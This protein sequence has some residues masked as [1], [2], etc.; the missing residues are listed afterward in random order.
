MYLTKKTSIKYISQLLTN[1]EPVDGYEEEFRIMESLHDLRCVEVQD[2]SEFTETDF[3]ELLKQLSKKNKAKY[4]F[5]LENLF[6]IFFSNCTKT[7][8]NL[9][10]TCQVKEDNLPSTLQRKRRKKRF[11]QPKVYTHQRRCTKG[12]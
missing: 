3:K 1:R 4:Q 10:V 12:F 2:N 6:T 8:G 5:I 9:N 7:F 11:Q